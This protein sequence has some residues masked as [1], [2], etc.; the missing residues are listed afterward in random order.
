[1]GLGPIPASTARE[2][3]ADGRWR[4]WITESA[5]TITATSSRTYRP[6]AALARL[7]RAREPYCRMPG[8]RTPASRCDLDHTIAWPEGETTI[9]NLG[10]LCRRHHVMKTHYGWRLEPQPPPGATLRPGAP[11]PPPGATPRAGPA[12]DP[13][14]TGSEPPD[15]GETTQRPNIDPW[16]DGI[17]APDPWCRPPGWF[18]ETPN[19]KTIYGDPS[20]P[21]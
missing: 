10:P 1:M 11:Q 21:F 2:L 19:G 15:Q 17:Q 5:G 7:I 6:G 4:A 12:A 20:P 14:S 13:D 8:C 9:E 16:R 18:W 3:A